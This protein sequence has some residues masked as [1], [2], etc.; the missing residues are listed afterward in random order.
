MAPSEYV[1]IIITTVLIIPFLILSV[2][3]CGLRSFSK[4]TSFD[5]AITVAVGSLL[6]TPIINSNISILKGICAIGIIFLLQFIISF[7]RKRFSIFAELIDNDPVFLYKDGSFLNDNLNKTRVTKSDVI[8]KLREANATDLSLV[9]AVV[10]E[11]TGDISVL[12]G[13]KVVDDIILERV[14]VKC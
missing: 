6:A 9:T 4:M 7:C 2:R 13:D 5:F 10:L 11:S 12:H 14:K 8:A 3:I 1:E